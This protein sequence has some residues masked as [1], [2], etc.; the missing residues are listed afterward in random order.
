MRRPFVA[1]RTA[2]HTAAAVG[3]AFRVSRDRPRKSTG[4]SCTERG[5][6]RGPREGIQQTEMRTHVVSRMLAF[7]IRNGR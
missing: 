2:V 4:C 5:G 1:V 3:T 7:P 6:S